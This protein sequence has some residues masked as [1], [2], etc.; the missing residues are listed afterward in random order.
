M[1]LLLLPLCS[2]LAELRERGIVVQ[3]LPSEQVFLVGGLPRFTPKLI[4]PGLGDA[5]DGFNPRGDVVA[6]GRLIREACPEHLGWLDGVYAGCVLD[7]ADGGFM[8]PA[9]AARALLEAQ[10][11]TQLLP[12]KEGGEQPPLLLVDESEREKPGDVLGQYRLDRVLGEGA[13]GRV[14]LAR[15][16]S[17]GRPAAV[18]VL[19]AE[20]TKNTHL[21]Q[22]FFHEARAVNQINHAHIVEILDFVEETSL[23]GLPRVY[24]VMEMLEGQSLTELLG[25]QH[26]GVARAVGIIRQVCDALQAAHDVGV[27]HRDVKPDNLFVLERDG[28][29][30]VKVL[31]FGVAKLVAPLGDVPMTTTVEGTIV[32]TPAYMAP[33]QATGGNADARTDLYSVGIVLYELL[34]GHPPF[35]APAFG[36]LVA[37]VLSSPP[38]PLPA[39]TRSGER[40]PHALWT[41]VKRCLAKNPE[42]RYPSL[43]ELGRALE[44]AALS[45]VRRG[46]PRWVVAGGAL[47]VVALGLGVVT[48]RSTLRTAE[49]TPVVIGKLVRD[50]ATTATQAPAV[51]AAQQPVEVAMTV[52]SEPPGARVV[53]LPSGRALGTTPLTAAVPRSSTPSRLRLEHAGRRATEV[54]VLPD[55]ELEVHVALPRAGRST[56][57]ASGKVER[58]K[59]KNPDPFKL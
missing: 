19:R 52:V 12:T 21:I 56:A 7:E 49:A 22:R 51:P 28:R 57:Q 1:A 34:A 17:L 32:G 44:A 23:S 26:P 20:H 48:G 38:P 45:P 6:L 42:D 10:P 14:F 33:E 3:A 37:Q 35:Q 47:A 50:P 4:G 55:A 27:I 18:K 58:K 30:F 40:I 31:D 29:D 25:K 46:P 5:G 13:M 16:V 9:E 53:E 15:H 36:Q 8:S 41:V 2:V 11:R 43:R 59:Q 39:Q 24:C 54:E